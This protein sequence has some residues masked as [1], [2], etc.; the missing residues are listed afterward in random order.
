[1]TKK[2]TPEEFIKNTTTTYFN[3]TNDIP[4]SIDWRAKGAVT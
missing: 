4:T 3:N 2:P 1:L